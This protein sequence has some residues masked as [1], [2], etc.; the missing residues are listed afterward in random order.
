M[1]DE[2]PAPAP[3]PKPPVGVFIEEKAVLSAPPPTSH[4]LPAPAFV[5]AHVGKGGR[6]VVDPKDGLRKP[7]YEKV[8]DAAGNVSF[9][10]AL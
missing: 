6:Y 5:D 8:T 2:K 3:A 10:K 4:P 7:V 9:R 1:A